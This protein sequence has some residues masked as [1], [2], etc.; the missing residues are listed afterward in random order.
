MVWQ[1]KWDKQ[2]GQ[3]GLFLQ[4]G[5]EQ[6]SWTMFELNIGCDNTIPIHTPWHGNSKQLNCQSVSYRDESR[7]VIIVL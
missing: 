1:K 3:F 6:N 4:T 7:R 5:P 2:G